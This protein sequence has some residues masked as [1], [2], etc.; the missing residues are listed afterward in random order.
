MNYIFFLIPILAVS[1]I[2]FQDSFAQTERGPNYDIDFLSPNPDGTYNYRYTSSPERIKLNDS[3][4]DYVFTETSN[5]LIV[6]TGHGSVTLDKTTCTFNFYKKGLI[7]SSP[8]FSDGIIA[9]MANDGTENW[10]NINSINNAVCQAYGDQTQLVAKKFVAGTGLLEYKYINTGKSWKT[11]LEATNLSTLTN[12]KFGFTQ[13]INLNKDTIHFGKQERNLDN[14]NGTSFNRTWL[15][16]NESRIINFLNDISF[17]FDLGFEKLKSVSIF[18]T[19]KN[20]SRLEFDYTY[21]SRVILP[22]QKLVIDPT[23]TSAVPTSE[24]RIGGTST[25]T[26][27]CDPTS[28][29]PAD[30]VIIAYKEPSSG[31]QCQ[32]GFL[33]F[34][35][36]GVPDSATVTGANIEYDVIISSNPINC[37]WK[38]LGFTGA[39]DETTYDAVSQDIGSV[40][41]ILQNDATCTG[42]VADGYNDVFNTGGFENLFKTDITGDD[43]ISLGFFFADKDKGALTHQVRLRSSDA[44]LRIDYTTATPPN[45]INDLT[46]TNL[47]NTSLDLLWTQPGL[48]GGNLTN[49]L[50]NFTTPYGNPQTFRANTTNTY[51]N[52]TGLTFG[53]QYSFRVSALTEGGYNATGN[54]LNVTTTSTTYSNPPVLTAFGPS[55]ASTQ[56]NLEFPSSTMQNINGYR[57]ERETPIG[58]G[59][60]TLVS[61][62]TTSTQYYNNTGLTSNVIYNYR[63]Y[64]MNGSGISTVSNEYDMTTFHLPDAVTILTATATSFSTVDLDWTAPTSY[65]PEII[66]YQINYTSP[67]GSPLI[68]FTNNTFSALTDAEVTELAIGDTYSF[69]VAAITV[70]GTNTTGTIANATTTTTYELGNLDSPDQLNTDDFKIFFNRTDIDA[71]SVELKV[72]YPSAYTLACDFV[73]KF[74]R[75]NDTFT[76]LTE[77]AMTGPGLDTNNVYSTFRFDNIDN[78]IV[79]AKCYDTL[80]DDEAKY[81][82]TITQFELLNQIDNLQNGTY[83]TQFEFGAIDGVLL[84]V[85]FIGMI[86]FNRVNPVAG[87]VFTVITVGALAYFEIIKQWTVIFPALALVVL[88][89]YTTTRKDD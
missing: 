70:H 73:Y 34:N 42:G 65:A 76:G 39:S 51:L 32:V 88:W 58:T 9:K 22:N 77:T 74:A 83:G 44:I 40:T 27:A 7:D 57:I 6:E 53:T 45:R 43:V 3:Y 24:G 17:D 21:N 80:G 12:K 71:D 86:G 10:T 35:V 72:I 55:S 66:G 46:Y 75:V 19:G 37:D 67:A 26:V 23:F 38:H 89:A 49:Y 1:L 30:G 52:V 81:V 59:W 33:N 41:D 48:N 15:E 54:I 8:L 85:V 78:E 36:A 29:V 16:T 5:L 60:V 62:T 13:T 61:N 64:A 69:R 4:V 82:I 68:V 50:V 18:N 28:T 25:A 47:S 31:G 14:F 87:V 20:G 79:N 63:V 2:S 84:I 11:Q 56:I